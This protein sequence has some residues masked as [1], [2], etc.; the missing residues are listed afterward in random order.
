M[1][2]QKTKKYVYTV[3]ITMQNNRACILSFGLQYVEV[4]MFSALAAICF[5]LKEDLLDSA[6]S[7]VK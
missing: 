7:G 5:P 6:H 3:N 2:K 4:T 1:Q